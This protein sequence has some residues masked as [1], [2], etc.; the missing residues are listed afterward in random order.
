MSTEKVRVVRVLLVEDNPHVAELI[1]EGLKGAARRELGGQAT[2]LFIHVPD[3]RAALSKL[4]EL[5]TLRPD[6][7]ICDLY[8]PVMDG[9]TFLEQLRARESVRTPVLA[10]S[11]G[12]PQAREAALAAGADGFLDKP[13]RLSELLAAV[14]QV[15]P[16]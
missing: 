14:R 15:T 1:Q 9:A 10:L 7:I 6:L 3:G 4:T 12:G 2:F 13:V 16:L 5:G 8:M 11:S